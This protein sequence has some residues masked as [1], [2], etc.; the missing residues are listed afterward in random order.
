MLYR[1]LLLLQCLN[2][3]LLLRSQFG[4]NGDNALP[5]LCQIKDGA[6]IQWLL[7]NTGATSANA[8][9]LVESAHAW[10]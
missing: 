10:G 6:C 3:Q 9:L 2:Q 1:L 8:P 4:R 5:N 7:M